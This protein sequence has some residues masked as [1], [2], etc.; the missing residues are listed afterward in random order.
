L[1]PAKRGQSLISPTRGRSIVN[2][3]A[4]PS[5]DVVCVELGDE[6][7][8]PTDN[9]LNPEGNVSL[10]MTKNI[11]SSQTTKQAN[12]YPQEDHVLSSYLNPNSSRYMYQHHH[13][14][15][16]QKE[17]QSSCWYHIS[18]EVYIILFLTMVNKAG[19]EMSVSSM[20][21]I[22]KNLFS[23]DTESI[24]YCMATIGAFVLPGN[25]LVNQF[26]KDLE[27]RKMLLVLMYLT[28]VGIT[29]IC[30]LHMFGL[31]YTVVRYLMGTML[32]F[33]TLNALEGLI[34]S[35]LSKL[36]SPELAKG[37]FNS[38]LLATEAGTFGRVMGDMAITMFGNV[39][40]PTSLVN[41]LY[42][43]LAAMVVVSIVLSLYHYKKLED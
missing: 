26:G 43:P 35:L 33:T 29:I 11:S 41:Q 16:S 31:P 18:T 37:T 4:V 7:W 27:E 20:P 13:S 42:F 40:E 23:W 9:D 10:E 22:M 2:Y 6:L 36:I 8:G 30:Q 14:R 17:K 3:G 34:M 38:G 21:F 12:L 28:M 32:V 15:S 19:Q 39:G 25:I 5:H 24:G 1:L